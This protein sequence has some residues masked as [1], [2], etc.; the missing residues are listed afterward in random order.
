[1][2]TIYPFSYLL[3]I[4]FI[5]KMTSDK[6]LTNAMVKPFSLITLQIRTRG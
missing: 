5:Y 1:M 4:F 2:F 6:S 3:I